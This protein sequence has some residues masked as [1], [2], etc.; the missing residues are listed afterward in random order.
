MGRS[1]SSSNS[2]PIGDLLGRRTEFL[3]MRELEADF[4]QQVERRS[5]GPEAMSSCHRRRWTNPALRGHVDG[6]L[7]R[8]D[9]LSTRNQRAVHRCKESCDILDVVT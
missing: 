7:D 9:K 1:S 3:H 8:E 4:D 5:D 2:G 6:V